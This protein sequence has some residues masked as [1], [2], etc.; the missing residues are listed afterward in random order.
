MLFKS[1]QRS[2]TQTHVQADVRASDLVKEAENVSKQV[3]SAQLCA[4]GAS[5]VADAATALEEENFEEAREACARARTYYDRATAVLSSTSNSGHSHAMVAKC[6]REVDAMEARIQ[7]SRGENEARISAWSCIELAQNA[8]DIGDLESARTNVAS[9]RAAMP[10]FTDHDGKLSGAVSEVEARLHDVLMERNKDA[11]R[12]SIDAAKEALQAERYDK[13][14]G[15]LDQAR[16]VLQGTG[17]P[18]L[19]D[20]L[21]HVQQMIYEGLARSEAE[22]AVLRSESYLSF[23][24]YDAARAEALAAKQALF[25]ANDQDMCAKVDDLL[26]RIEAAESADRQRKDLAGKTLRAQKALDEGNYTAS[27][28]IV[29]VGLDARAYVVSS[30]MYACACFFM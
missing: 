17:A 7:Q 8:I 22:G 4:D 12:K 13:A 24:K 5:E 28:E 6:V 16:D 18:E 20:E 26:Q 14:Q 29:Q 23:E 30:C 27:L 1:H 2:E 19:Y 15:A 3:D 11:A 10:R 25:R 9:A 21:E